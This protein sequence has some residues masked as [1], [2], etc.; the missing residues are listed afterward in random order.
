MAH[1]ALSRHVQ[2]VTTEKGIAKDVIRREQKSDPFCQTLQ[3]KSAAARSEFFYDQ[4]GIIYK[5]QKHGEPLLV[6][7]K[8]L[9]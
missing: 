3:V 1:D 2:T 9:E 8:S 7:P 4:D 6:V 5:R